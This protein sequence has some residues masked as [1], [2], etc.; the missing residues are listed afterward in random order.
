MIQHIAKHSLRLTTASLFVGRQA[1]ALPPS[2]TRLHPVHARRTHDIGAPAANVQNAAVMTLQAPCCHCN[3]ERAA[4]GDMFHPSHCSSCD[5][6]HRAVQAVGTGS[7]WCWELRAAAMT[8]ALQSSEPQTAPS[9]GRLLPTRQAS[10]PDIFVT[11]ICAHK[12]I[13]A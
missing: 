11:Q 9:W 13:H 10:V 3:G 12:N 2:W 7:C 1:A 8:R 4:A 6:L 5:V